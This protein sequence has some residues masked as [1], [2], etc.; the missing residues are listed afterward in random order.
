MLQETYAS[1]ET[2]WAQKARDWTARELG[3]AAR[4]DGSRFCLLA[5]LIQ[6]LENHIEYAQGIIK[7]R[8][9][10]VVKRLMGSRAS[11]AGLSR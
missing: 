9:T 4:P 1:L 5:W 11:Q 10:D 8:R 3:T 2:Y 6:R 7:K